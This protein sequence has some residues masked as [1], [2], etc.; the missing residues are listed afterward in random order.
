MR[1]AATCSSETFVD[2][3]G[4]NTVISLKT[5]LVRISCI[6]TRVSEPVKTPVE[7]IRDKFNYYR[8]ENSY[9]TL[10][11]LKQTQDLL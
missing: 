9:V 4:I 5:E 3:S 8:T 10:L 7:E 11:H 2:F 6:S 1:M